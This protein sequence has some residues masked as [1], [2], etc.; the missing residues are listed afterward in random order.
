MSPN[1]TFNLGVRYELDTNVKN[2]SGYDEISPLVRP[3][4][5]GDRKR[6]SNNFAP[7]IGFNWSTRDGRTSIRGGYGIYYD[8]V[9]LEIASLERGLDGSSLAIEVRAGNVFFLDPNTGQFP[10]FAPSISNPFTGFVLPGAGA[11]GI[12]IID[13]TLQNP[14]VQ[15]MSLGFQHELSR[16]FILRADYVHNFGTSFIIGRTVGTVPSIRQLA[17][18]NVYS[19]SSQVRKRSMTGCS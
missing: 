16:N 14:M 8:R 13:N 6:D 9:T 1:L 15:Q 12:D 3:F 18:P 7:R 10:P 19:I 5:I 11:G 4:L 17:G 2:I